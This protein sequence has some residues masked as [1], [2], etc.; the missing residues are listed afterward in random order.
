MH[1]LTRHFLDLRLTV[2]AFRQLVVEVHRLVFTVASLLITLTA[3]L[4]CLRHI[5]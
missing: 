1:R 5:L 3:V 4:A 2:R